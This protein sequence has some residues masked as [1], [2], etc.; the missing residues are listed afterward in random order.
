MALPSP[1]I[2]SNNFQQL[3]LVSWNLFP[4]LVFVHLKFLG[5]VVP[6][7]SGR[8]NDRP[9]SS[10]QEHLRVV[11]L[12]SVAALVLSAA[13][14]VGAIAVSIVTVVFPALFDAKY[15]EELSPASMFLPPVSISRSETVGDGVRGFFLWDQA[16][17]YPVMILVMLLQLRTAAVSQGLSTSWAKLLG[18]AVL[19]T[20]IAGPGSACLALSWLRDEMLFG[21]DRE[22]S[23]KHE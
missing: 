6:I 13:V 18:L 14:H 16:F 12:V 8:R 21:S 4:L 17:G 22:A 3:A 15:V 1:R 20:C 11:T 10:P 23:A 19:I 9:A 2:V 7:F 5:A